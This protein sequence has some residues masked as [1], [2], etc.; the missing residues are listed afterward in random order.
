MDDCANAS[1]VGR[2]G[3]LRFACVRC[4]AADG[5][6]LGVVKESSESESC[7]DCDGEV[8]TSSS[9]DMEAGE[10]GSGILKQSRAVAAARQKLKPC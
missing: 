10:Q 7:A 1:A 3:L 2:T 9:V 6:G 8:E 5:P 4:S